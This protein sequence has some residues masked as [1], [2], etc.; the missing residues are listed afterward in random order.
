MHFIFQLPCE[1]VFNNDRKLTYSCSYFPETE[2]EHV[3]KINFSRKPIPKSPYH[4]LG[5]P[6]PDQ[7]FAFCLTLQ[8]F[9]FILFCPVKER[10]S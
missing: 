5:L 3:V 1:I 8:C 2:G 4:V 6:N 10:A 7:L 9:T